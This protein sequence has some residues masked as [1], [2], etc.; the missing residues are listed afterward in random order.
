MNSQS[1]QQSGKKRFKEQKAGDGGLSAGT[2]GDNHTT[3]K[4]DANFP[5]LGD[6]VYIMMEPEEDAR[7][8]VDGTLASM[9]MLEED[10]AQ[11]TGCNGGDQ[12]HSH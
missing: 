4:P 7:V 5:Q 9:G 11:G 3:R 12:H 6:R 2:E 8:A 1:P 10:L